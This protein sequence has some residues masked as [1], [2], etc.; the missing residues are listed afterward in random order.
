MV[1]QG[2]VRYDGIHA[3]TFPRY[4]AAGLPARQAAGGLRLLQGF[5]DLGG[6]CR[7]RYVEGPYPIG[8][9][10]S[11]DGPRCPPGSEQVP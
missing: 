10:P 5:S 4:S 7:R 9:G 3:S 1:L 6:P 8:T 2:K 11:P